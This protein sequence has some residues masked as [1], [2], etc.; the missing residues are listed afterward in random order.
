LILAEDI[1]TRD[2]A[3]CTP[4]EPLLVV[5]KKLATK[6]FSCLIIVE[7]KTPVGIVTERD[8]VEV[9]FDT[10]QGVTWTELAIRNFMSSPVVS[11]AEDA[12][13]NELVTLS[14][15]N[16]IRHMPVVN[17]FG[18]LIGIITQSDIVSGFYN[19]TF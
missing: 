8:L 18:E 11:V 5:V 14:H 19:T 2:V 13:L 6:K 4:D 7:D 15:M 1:M 16:N 12:S 10:L 17:E 3:T 9:L